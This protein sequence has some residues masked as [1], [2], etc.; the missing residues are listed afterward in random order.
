MSPPSRGGCARVPVRL[1]PLG[2]LMTRSL[3]IPTGQTHVQRDMR[4]LFERLQKGDIDPS[5]SMTHRMGLEGM[6]DGSEIFLNKQDDCVNV[7][8]NRAQGGDGMA[9]NRDHR[10]SPETAVHVLEHGNIYFFYRPKVEAQAV[11]GVDDVQRLYMILSPHG[12]HSY[13]LII[14]GEK[15]LPAVTRGG[16]RKS[17]GFIEKVAHQAEDVEDELDPETHRTKTRGERHQPAARPAG[18]GVYAIVRHGD[19]THLAYV[20]ELPAEPGEVQRA[21]NIVEEGSYI[22]SVKNPEAPSPPGLGLDEAR[23][24]HFPKELL[25]RFGGRRFISVDPPDFLDYE[26]AEILLI[27]AGQGISEEHGLHLNPEHETEATAEIFNHLRLEKSLHPT[28]P[29]LKGRWE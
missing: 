18:E 15:R 17:W 1:R 3:T 10:S 24:A 12:K 9:R 14:V 11:K 2:S 19:H 6:P 29:L 4:P 26:G 23:R 5:F 7:V 16:D 13:R 28:M 8:V 27:G 21:L 20:L 25:E 22:I